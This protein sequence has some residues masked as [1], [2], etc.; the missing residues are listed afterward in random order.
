MA[1]TPSFGLVMSTSSYPSGAILVRPDFQH[2][3]LY[4]N[5]TNVDTKLQIGATMALPACCLCLCI[6]LERIASVRQVGT[7]IAEKHRRMLFDGLMCWAVPIIYMALRALHS[8][9]LSCTCR[10][11]TNSYRLHCARASIRHRRRPRLSA[12]H[13]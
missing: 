10:W 5:L 8:F 11:L 2:L 7:T 9:A 3:F 12:R 4:P 6:H 1:R 13:L